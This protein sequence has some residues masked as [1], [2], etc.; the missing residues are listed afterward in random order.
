MSSMPTLDLPLGTYYNQCRRM[1]IIGGT[2]AT[3]PVL[4]SGAQGAAPVAK[5]QSG[6][7]G[8]IDVACPFDST[9][10]FAAHG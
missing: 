7:E 6:D 1:P 10:R 4:V 3:L 8:V 9:Y 5:I 2:E